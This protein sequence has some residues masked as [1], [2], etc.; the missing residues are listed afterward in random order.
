MALA[1]SLLVADVSHSRSF[2]KKHSLHYKVYYLCFRLSQ[3]QQL[4]S[5]ILSVERFNLFSF[6]EKD[7]G[8]AP[9]H[10]ENWARSV[11]AQKGL[12]QADGDIVLLTLPR[13][14]GYAFNPV[15]FWFCLDKEGQLRAVISEVNNT[16]GERHAYVCAHEDQRIIDKDDWLRTQKRF[17][18]SPFLEVSGYYHF[19][20]AYSE[21]KIGV[22]I[23][24]YDN[25]KM[26]LTTSV[27]GK[28][29]TLSDA[30][31]IRCFF[32]YP[33][34]TLKVIAMIH[35]QAL[36]LVMKGIKYHNKPP[37]PLQDITP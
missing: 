22:W 5:K 9:M 1:R 2:P 28:R 4:S 10:A 12:T 3:L 13:V 7:H 16:F 18:V 29:E 11:L 24:H 37:K 27:T 19:R 31:L 30:S 34:I 23:D 33:A 25:D 35:C 14:M 15:S 36:R 17:H 6:F 21:D 26:I 32:R 20:F 8:F